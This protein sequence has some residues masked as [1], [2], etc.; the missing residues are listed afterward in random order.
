V[1]RQSGTA[2]SVAASSVP[3]FPS[4]EEPVAAGPQAEYRSA[5]TVARVAA[6]VAAAGGERRDRFVAH[7]F[8]GLAAAGDTG[9]AIAPNDG[10]APAVS[11]AWGPHSLAAAWVDIPAAVPADIPVAARVDT[12]AA[13]PAEIFAV[14]PTDSGVA[15]RAGLTFAPDG[16]VA[17]GWVLDGGGAESSDCDGPERDTAQSPR[18]A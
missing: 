14:A 18:S 1:N 13:V 8:A 17:N 10:L 2:A 12:H 7:A 5:A 15:L 4:A 9:L 6:A 16:L 3:M 11:T